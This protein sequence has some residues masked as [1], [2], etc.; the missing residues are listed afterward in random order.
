VTFKWDR[1]DWYENGTPDGS[2]VGERFEAGFIAQEVDA[3]QDATGCADVINLIYKSNLDQLELHQLKFVPIL[4]KAVQELSAQ[5]TA[6]QT[7]VSDL[8]A[9]Q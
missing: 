8:Q 5:V 1:R 2:K 3:A 7:Q 6:L 4:V 9:S